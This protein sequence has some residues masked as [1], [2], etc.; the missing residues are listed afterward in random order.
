MNNMNEVNERR[1]VLVKLLGSLIGIYN[2]YKNPEKIPNQQLQIAIETHLALPDTTE[3]NLDKIIEKIN[4]IFLPLIKKKLIS[5]DKDE[6]SPAYIKMTLIYF[7]Q[8]LARL[9]LTQ[10]KNIATFIPPQIE[11]PK[12]KRTF[13]KKNLTTTN[14]EENG[15]HYQDIPNFKDVE[16]SGAISS[17]QQKV[18]DYQRMPIFDNNFNGPKKPSNPSFN[19]QTLPIKQNNSVMQIQKKAVQPSLHNLSNGNASKITERKLPEIPQKQKIESQTT[20]RSFPP[21]IQK[22]GF[23]N[24][25]KET[26]QDKTILETDKNLTSVNQTSSLHTSSLNSNSNTLITETLLSKSNSNAESKQSKK[27]PRPLRQQNPS[28]PVNISRTENSQIPIQTS[29]QQQTFSKSSEGQQLLNYSHINSPVRPRSNNKKSDHALILENKLIELK[30]VSTFKVKA[31]EILKAIGEY[32]KDN[33]TQRK[34]I[35]ELETFRMGPLLL[36]QE[37]GEKLTP[38]NKSA[39]NAFE[40][41]CDNAIKSVRGEETTLGCN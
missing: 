41:A 18:G 8:E 2:L 24:F 26:N 6:V 21:N 22:P 3:V 14:K 23:G 15:S 5:N 19:S 20:T 28:S 35:K 27:P 12:F 16:K 10:E 40:E 4:L 33:S 37:L 7:N 13:T 34:P 32:I 29:S 39:K 36:L 31:I 9:F 30:Q 38:G 25:N 17:S 1:D 11:T